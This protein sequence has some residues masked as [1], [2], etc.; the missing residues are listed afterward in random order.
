V[1]TARWG[2]VFGGKPPTLLGDV[3]RAV[4]VLVKFVDKSGHCG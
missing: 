3:G 4:N 2:A 1:A